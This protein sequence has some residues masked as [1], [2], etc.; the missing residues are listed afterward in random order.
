MCNSVPLRN[1]A[2]AVLGSI[3]SSLL[4][5]ED[6]DGEDSEDNESEG[7]PSAGNGVGDGLK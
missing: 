4:L 6:E 5:D 1:H 2:S 3:P 7:D